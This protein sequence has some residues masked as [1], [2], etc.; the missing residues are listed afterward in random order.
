[1]LNDLGLIRHARGDDADAE[2]LLANALRLRRE[3][4]G[5]DDLDVASGL[6][7]AGWFRQRAGDRPEAASLYAESLRIRRARLP[8]GH[9][10]IREAQDA[11]AE[12]SEERIAE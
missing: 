7:L 2:R 9:P 11:L 5:P 12:V 1:M 4:L 6:L 8:D 3:A 10:L